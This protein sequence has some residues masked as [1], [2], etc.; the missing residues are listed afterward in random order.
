MQQLLNSSCWVQF[1][2][3]DMTAKQDHSSFHVSAW[4]R[5]LESIPPSITLIIPESLPTV[6]EEPPVKRGLVYLIDM[7]LH[8][9]DAVGDPPSLPSC[10]PNSGRPRRRR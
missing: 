1:V 4:C 8:R 7:V 5:R 9:S 10:G 6:S 2:H 3:L